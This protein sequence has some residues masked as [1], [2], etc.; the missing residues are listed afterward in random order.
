M[1]RTRGPA[2]VPSLDEPR[3]TQQHERIKALMRFNSGYTPV[4]ESGCWI[5][6][7]SDKNHG[8][9]RFRVNGK[10][11]MVHRFSYEL[12][13]GKIQ[14]GLSIDHL[15]R[16]RCCVNPIHLEAV[17]HRTNVLRGIS[18]MSQ[19]AAKKFCINGHELIGNNLYRVSSRRERSCKI[20]HR[21][22]YQA[23]KERLNKEKRDRYRDDP[24]YRQHIL[25]KNNLSRRSH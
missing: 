23:N 17:A 4:P 24:I 10:L 5:W 6:N 22:L 19:N 20:C 16:V 14:D 7:G 3:L 21:A 2:Y 18:P 9:C 8:Y 15:C 1:T 13:N 12:F 25:D 11:M